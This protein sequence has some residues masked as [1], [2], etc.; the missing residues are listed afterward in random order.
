MRARARAPD[1]GRDA[2]SPVTGAPGD[3]DLLIVGAGEVWSPAAAPADGAA[4]LTAGAVGGALQETPVVIPGGAVAIVG[5]R[6]VAV[7]PG[8]EIERRWRPRET[9]DAGGGAVTPSF[10]DPHTH[11]AFGGWRGEEFAARVAGRPLPAGPGRG[12]SRTVER[13]RKTPDAEL[14]ALIRGRLD[15]CLHNGVTLLEAK[16]GYGLTVEDE[17]RL[18]RLT[19]AAAAG[20]PVEVVTTVLA[21][22]ALPPGYA[23]RAPAYLDE[24]AWPVTRTAHEQSLAQFVDAFVEEGAFTAEEVEPYLRR[25][26]DLGLGIRIHADQLTHGG[27]ARLAARLGAATAEHLERATAADAQALAEAGTVAVLLPGAALTVDGRGGAR[28]PTAALLAAGVPI[29]LATD[30]NPGTSTVASPA[31]CLGL[32]CRLFGLSPEAAWTAFTANAAASLGRGRSHGRVAAGYRA[33]LCVWEVP[34]ARDVAYL[35]DAHRPRK[36]IAGGR[37]REQGPV[38]WSLTGE[39]E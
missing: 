23:A 24:V 19:R 30:F 15:R 13:T 9:L 39:G 3:C 36:V 32:A 25:A 2:V 17:L 6:I 12:I 34:R 28:P 37:V 20:H 16:S 11:L 33:E 5:D 31:L 10:C 35:L 4:G 1:P 7:G 18:L 21:A 29:A 14:K 22:H 26:R 38:P 27:G 8:A